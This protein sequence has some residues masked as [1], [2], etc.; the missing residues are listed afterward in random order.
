MHDDEVFDV[1]HA[2]HDGPNGGHFVGKGIL[3]K[4][5]TL[6]TIGQPLIKMNVRDCKSLLKLMRCV[7]SHKFH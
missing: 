3:S 1:L 4:F 5:C 6:D 2:F 7:Y